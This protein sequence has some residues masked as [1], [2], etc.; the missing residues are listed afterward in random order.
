MNLDKSRDILSRQRKIY[1]WFILGLF[2]VIGITQAII[3]SKLDMIQ[4]DG[5][6]IN[7]AGRQRMLSQAIAKDIQ[8]GT[9][10]TLPRE[11]V[12]RRVRDNLKRLVAMQEYLFDG[13]AYGGEMGSS[14]KD[15]QTYNSITTTKDELRGF[16]EAFIDGERFSR[17]ELIELDIVSRYFVDQ[18]DAI[19]TTH[20]RGSS[21]RITD[22]VALKLAIL[23]FVVIST[24]VFWMRLVKPTLDRNEKYLNRLEVLR[25]HLEEA[26]NALEK[27]VKELNTTV[28]DLTSARALVMDNLAIKDNIYSILTHDIKNMLTGIRLSI[29]VIGSKE[30][31]DDKREERMRVME[32]YLNECQELLVDVV[33]FFKG[34]LVENLPIERV[35]LE[36]IIEEVVGTYQGLI[37]E[38]GIR[39][40]TRLY[41]DSMNSN[42]LFVKT[43]LRN[44]LQNAV[45][46][47]KIGGTIDISFSQGKL[48]NSFTITDSGFGMDEATV[49][50]LASVYSKEKTRKS[51]GLGMVIIYKMVERLGGKIEVIS[52]LGE[53]TTIVIDLP[54]IQRDK[55]SS[56]DAK[57]RIKEKSKLFLK[58]I[59]GEEGMNLN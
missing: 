46:Y 5:E 48:N 4:D 52:K 40:S 55:E 57:R 8:I 18:M 20:T 28:E 41:S 2:A 45:K 6:L 9:A 43:I 7:W 25:G 33:E 1:T 3:F 11:V 36:P 37:D 27:K 39:V 44:V 24:V 50:N 15:Y 26:N 29:E 19:I 23:A 35:E 17:R 16:A 31:S 53:G 38:K 10:G 12:A 42:P 32:V 14:I 58:T 56:A 21:Q 47:N 22:L 30:L 13:E 49:H 59:N 34:E 51:T 54:R